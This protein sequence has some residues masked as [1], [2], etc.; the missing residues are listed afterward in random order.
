M[1][2][3]D[4]SRPMMSSMFVLLPV[5]DVELAAVPGVPAFAGPAPLA[6]AVAVCSWVGVWLA[7]SDSSKPT[8]ELPTIM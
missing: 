7:W 1:P 5:E 3:A 4:I 2:T 6:A 8:P